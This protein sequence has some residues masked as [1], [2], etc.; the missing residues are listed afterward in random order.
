[1]RQKEYCN[2]KLQLDEHIESKTSLDYW[3][4]PYLKKHTLCENLY[5]EALNS[6]N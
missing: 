4:K 6:K 2:L 5:D 3:T 1:M